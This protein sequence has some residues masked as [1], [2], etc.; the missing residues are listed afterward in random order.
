MLR[1]NWIL[2]SIPLA[3]A[4]QQHYGDKFTVSPRAWHRIAEKNKEEGFLND[5]RCLRLAIDSGGCHGY[6]Y[7]FSFDMID[8]L[9]K[10]EDLLLKETDVVSR[11]DPNFTGADPPPQVVVDNI[12]LGKLKKSLIDYYSELKGAAFVV[13]GNELVDQSCACALSF[14]LKPKAKTSSAAAA[15]NNARVGMETRQQ[16][17]AAQSGNGDSGHPLKHNIP[18]HRAVQR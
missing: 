13:V 14:S 7:K 15:T 11:D 10:E 6:L 12:S 4:L 3:V 18:R 1:C 2:R 16:E 9:N 5:K 17:T 8:S